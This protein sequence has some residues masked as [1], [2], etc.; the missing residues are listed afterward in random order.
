M[1]VDKI[2]IVHLEEDRNI[3][4]TQYALAR[5]QVLRVGRR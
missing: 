2:G 1:E 5:R 4:P 3:L